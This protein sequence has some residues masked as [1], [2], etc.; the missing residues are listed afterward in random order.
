[1][2]YEKFR[3]IWCVVVREKTWKESLI[4]VTYS[5]VYFYSIQWKKV[6]EKRRFNF[7]HVESLVLVDTK[8]YLQNSGNYLHLKHTF[9]DS[10]YMNDCWLCDCGWLHCRRV[11]KCSKKGP[12]K[13]S[14]DKSK[15]R[16]MMRRQSAHRDRSNT[17]TESANL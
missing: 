13:I 12:W 2:V 15:C 9:I 11:L 17:F 10:S 16:K 1:M 4:S 7:E 3:F 6:Q 5:K 14:T 8:S